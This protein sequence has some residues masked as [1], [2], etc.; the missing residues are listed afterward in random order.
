ML[1]QHSSLSNGGTVKITKYCIFLYTLKI[2]KK[3]GY[4]FLRLLNGI[5]FQTNFFQD[6]FL[7]EMDFFEMGFF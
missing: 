3:E 6:K 1:A 4:V 7:F 2:L 5:L